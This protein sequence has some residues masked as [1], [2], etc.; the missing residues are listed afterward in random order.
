MTFVNPLPQGATVLVAGVGEAEGARAS[1]AALACAAAGLDSAALL[2][3][4]GGRPPRPTLLAAAAAQALEE[5]LAAHLP[6]LRAAARGQ[7]CHLAVPAEPEGLEAAFAA[8]T[9]ARGLGAVVHLPPQLLQAGV[10]GKAGPRPGGVMLRADL[11]RDRPLVALAVRDLIAR[12]VAVAVLKQRLG[13]VSERRAL[14]GALPAGAAG[15]LPERIVG[16]L[17]GGRR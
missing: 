8:A 13:W 14:F 7:V 11:E 17:Y 9:V 2:V 12:G 3:D 10:E 15:G 4:A 6:D 5:R 1:A 16:R